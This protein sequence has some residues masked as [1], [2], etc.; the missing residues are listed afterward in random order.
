MH[1]LGAGRLKFHRLGR[2]EMASDG[3]SFILNIA[4]FVFNGLILGAV[5]TVVVAGNISQAL[6]EK[7][8]TG[9]AVASVSYSRI[10]GFIGA[11]AVTSF[12]WALGNILIY[13]MLTE[14]NAAADV[15]GLIN[16]LSR[17]FL[18]GSA[19]FLPYAFNQLKSVFT[20][21]A[22][23]ATT[24]SKSAQDA[25]N[26]V[27]AAQDDIKKNAADAAAAA[28]DAKKHAENA[29]DSAKKANDA[30]PPAGGGDDG[31]HE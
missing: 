24:A 9:N 16:G 26:Q 2:C 19:L 11:A 5:V 22:A 10:T 7:D 8:P 29:E 23:A 25:L 3:I 28:G 15:Y 21:D 6:K 27:K 30:Q 12:F 1:T 13:K 20:G 31:P 4:L 14:E 17:Y 18:I